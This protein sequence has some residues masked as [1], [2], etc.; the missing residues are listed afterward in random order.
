MERKW[1]AKEKFEMIID[2]VQHSEQTKKGNSYAI[3]LGSFH[4]PLIE[5]IWVVRNQEYETA[6]DISKSFVRFSDSNEIN[7]VKDGVLRI[8]NVE[9]FS[10]RD[11]QYFSKIQPLHHHTRGAYPS[12]INVYSFAEKPESLNV[13]TGSM[14]ATAINNMMLNLNLTKDAILKNNRVMVFARNFNTLVFKNG[15]ARLK[16]VV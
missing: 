8:N 1:F 7:P 14:N 9:R 13:Y 6:T 11:G 5:L 3:D 4:H 16:Y 2:Q 10:K 12:G 15:F